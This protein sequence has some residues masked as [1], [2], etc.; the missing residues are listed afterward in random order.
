MY[1]FN[2]EYKFSTW[3]FSI[4]KN[5]SIDYI[6]KNKKKVETSYFQETVSST[7][8]SPEDFVDLMETKRNILEFIKSLNEIDK[9]ILLLRYTKDKITFQQI[10]LILNIPESTIKKRYYN[11]HDKYESFISV[12]HVN[13]IIE[14]ISDG[15][16]IEN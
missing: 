8:L 2:K 9:Q 6:R 11:L 4:A 5:K 16:V 7:S 10:A 3:L 1:S 13:P 12:I 15:R 14:K